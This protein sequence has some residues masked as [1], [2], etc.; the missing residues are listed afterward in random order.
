MQIANDGPRP[1]LNRKGPRGQICGFEINAEVTVKM[2]IQKPLALAP[3]EAVERTLAQFLAPKRCRRSRSTNP[4]AWPE[5][6]AAA[7]ENLPGGTEGGRSHGWR[8]TRPTATSTKPSG[9]GPPGGCKRSD[10]NKGSGVDLGVV[11]TE[12]FE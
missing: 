12:F 11:R 10:Q 1:E 4:G 3:A 7:V 9:R 5:V 2:K 8:R 6:H